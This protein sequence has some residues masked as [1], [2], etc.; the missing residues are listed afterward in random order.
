MLILCEM[1][2]VD[3]RSKINSIRSM[4]LRVLYLDNAKILTDKVGKGVM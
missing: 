1:N 2:N 3:K 4:L